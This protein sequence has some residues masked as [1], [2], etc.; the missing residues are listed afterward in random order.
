MKRL[1]IA[2][3]AMVTLTANAQNMNKAHMERHDNPRTIEIG[4][5]NDAKIMIAPADRNE[6]DMV[7]RLIRST[8]FDDRKLEVAKVCLALRPMYA[9]DIETIAKT[10]SFD[11]GKLKFLEYAYKYCIDR[12][13]MMRF[14]NLFSFRSNSD[15]WRD[16]LLKNHKNNTRPT[17]QR[18]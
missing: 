15:K 9:A 7:I 18:R 4:R 8:S 6:A 5:R 11:D 10:F 2:F 12:E 17:P 16:F 14:T 3:L 13:N 1:F